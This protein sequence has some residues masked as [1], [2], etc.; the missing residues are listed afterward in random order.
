MTAVAGKQG[1]GSTS[2]IRSILSVTKL[3]QTHTWS[4]MLLGYGGILGTMSAA[5]MG[6]NLEATSETCLPS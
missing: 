1:P 6:S 2:G 4:S 3:K 5:G